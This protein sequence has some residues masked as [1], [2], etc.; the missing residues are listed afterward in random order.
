MLFQLC[1]PS[2]SHAQPGFDY[3][4][5]F[6]ER[7]FVGDVL[8]QG[9]CQLYEVVGKETGAGVAY[10]ELD[11]LCAAGD[12]GLFPQGGQLST[13]FGGEVT[14]PCQVGLHGL[15][16]AHCFFFA[17]PVLEDA[18]GFFD[19]APAVFGR[20]VQDA[21]QLALANDHVHFAAE[22]G[23]REEFLDVQQPARRTVDGVFGTTGAKEGAG[24]GYFAVLDGK[25][26]V[27]VVD[28]QRHMGP[29]KWRAARGSGEDDVFHFSAA[30]CFC[31]L[32]AHDPG[33]RIHHVG[34]AGSIGTDDGSDAGLEVERR[35]RRKR[36][37]SA[38]GQTFQMQG[39]SVLLGGPGVW[40]P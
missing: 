8:F 35:G 11:G 12:F 32:L 20:S 19:E 26:V 24:N 13:D 27:R 34:F 37:E 18:R 33:Q 30:Q 16:L 29:A 23:I 38:D 6:L 14:E 28:G 40:S 21:V 17:P 1:L 7:G 22:T 36:L 25:R 2:P 31:A 15:Q 5:A 10:V 9:G 4:A 3:L 39:A